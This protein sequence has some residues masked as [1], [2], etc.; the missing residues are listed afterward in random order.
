M[1][2]TPEERLQ[3]KRQAEAAQRLRDASA[4]GTTS[5]QY[6][7][8][9]MQRYMSSWMSSD[10]EK[11]ELSGLESHSTGSAPATYTYGHPDLHTPWNFTY[12]Q[13]QEL[14]QR[15]VTHVSNHL[16][17]W[18]FND[19]QL[20]E[21]RRRDAWN[22]Q[23]EKADV[24]E[25]L[26]EAGQGNPHYQ[27]KKDAAGRVYERTDLVGPRR[28]DYT[29]RD[30]QVPM[31]PSL[32]A[33]DPNNQRFTPANYAAMENARHELMAAMEVSAG[34]TFSMLAA[35]RIPSVRAA[36]QNVDLPYQVFV[37]AQKILDNAVA[38]GLDAPKTR[39]E[40]DT[41][42]K[43]DG[44]QN[45]IQ[46]YKNLPVRSEILA[47]ADAARGE[48]ERLIAE[49]AAKSGRS[50]QELREL[51]V[52][53]DGY[54]SH[55]QIAFIKARGKDKYLD[56]SQGTGKTG[57]EVMAVLYGVATGQ[58]RFQDINF[59][60]PT[61]PATDVLIKKFD[62]VA[63]KGFLPGVDW[64][65]AKQYQFRTIYSRHLSMLYSHPM[66]EDGGHGPSAMEQLEK[67]TGRPLTQYTMV[68]FLSV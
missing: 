30:I 57:T 63:Y 62:Q 7:N 65:K 13:I 42:F 4:H 16:D 58:Y 11:G 44:T 41:A 18:R 27:P 15:D 1:T 23:D 52:G 66:I 21:L 32:P 55:E 37:V 17:P 10:T 9:E 49:V 34:G 53:K 43:P 50:A 22:A 54:F 40:L 47:K 56:G 19:A 24:F 64:E 59:G 5:W 36:F 14:H 51:T 25:A 20:E 61:H 26:H 31:Y 3:L 29:S 67:F 46:P 2:L 48:S 28:T 6:Y 39:K 12:N 33:Q 8:G 68:G 45:A 35:M 38:Q 60:S